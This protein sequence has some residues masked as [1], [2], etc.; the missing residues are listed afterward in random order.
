MTEERY[1]NRIYVGSGGMATVYHAWDSLVGRDVALK[2]IAEQLRGNVDVREM[3]LNEARKMA[4]VHHRNVVQVYDVLYENEVP[5]IIQEFMAGGSLAARIG[6][7]KMSVPE[8]INLLNDVLYGLRAIHASGLIHR[9]MKPD[10]ILCNDKGEW[11]VA[12]FGVAMS[13]DEEVLPFVGSKYAAPEVLNAPDTIS[14]RSDLYSI[15]IMGIELLLGTE[16]FEAAAREAVTLVHGE[17]PGGKVSSAA[18][19][20]RWVSSDAVLPPLNELEPSISPEVAQ[21]FAALTQRKPEDRPSDCDVVL[22]QIAELREGESMRMGAPTA[23]DPKV[24]KKAAEA[25]AKSGTPLWFKLIIAILLAF[26]LAVG[27]L[28]LLPGGGTPV[29]IDV[30]PPDA[31]LQINGVEVP[32]TDP[33]IVNLNGGEQ[34]L[35]QREGYADHTANLSGELSELTAQDDG[36]RQYAVALERAAFAVRIVTEPAGATVAVNGVQLGDKTPLSVT[37]KAGDALEL[38]TPGYEA[39]AAVFDQAMPGLQGDVTADELLTYSATL[40][41]GF[42]LG[43]SAMAER[44]L[45]EK[46][47]DVKPLGVKLA[48]ALDG[49]STIAL[50][51]PVHYRIVPQNNGYLTVL[52]MSSDDYLTLIYP[53]QDDEPF[54]VKSTE[55]VLV[56]SALNIEAAEPVGRDWFVFLLTR[57]ALQIPLIEGVEPLDNWARY[58]TFGQWQSS[59]ERFLVWLVEES[60]SEVIAAEVVPLDIVAAP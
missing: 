2:E 21:F 40:E 32:R 28:L 51:V 37:L 56:G 16:V 58:Y 22:G 7:S 17:L 55:E 24:K 27:A 44:Y 3:F 25:G 23:L 20:Q 38:S 39:H 30:D 14:V 50:G 57:D 46:W 9:D 34:I 1:Q 18:F 33:W 45:Q 15:G 42:Y 11:K 26:L 49:G 41:R 53:N 13:G 52:H 47:A 8:V 31:T 6:A 12:D 35:V 48:T 4:Q 59:A 43:S 60:G 54:R 29:L 10:N 5:T 36:Q 19:W